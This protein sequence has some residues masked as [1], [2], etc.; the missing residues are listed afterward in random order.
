MYAC[1]CQIGHALVLCRARQ[2]HTPRL[3]RTHHEAVHHKIVVA[4]AGEAW[5]SF[6]MRTP[7]RPI[8]KGSIGEAR[9]AEAPATSSAPSFGDAAAFARAGVRE[10]CDVAVAAARLSATD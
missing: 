8:K 4:E 7:S 2:C 5:L 3:T 9:G 1:T 10:A 6:R